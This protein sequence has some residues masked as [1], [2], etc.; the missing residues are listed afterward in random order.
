MSQISESE[1]KSMTKK[2]NY[3]RGLRAEIDVIEQNVQG[4]ILHEI[5]QVID[6]YETESNKESEK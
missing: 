5:L 6:K 1:I 2:Q 4:M 3:M